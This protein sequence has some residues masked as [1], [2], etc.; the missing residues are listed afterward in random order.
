MGRCVLL[1]ERAVGLAKARSIDSIYSTAI[2]AVESLVDFGWCGVGIVE[3]GSLRYRYYRGLTLPEGWSMP[4]DGRGVTVRAV[5]TAEAQYVPDVRRD[6]DYVS[7]SPEDENLAELVVPVVAG[8][9]VRAVINVEGR[10]VDSITVED[11]ELVAAL[12]LHVGAALER[13]SEIEALEKSVAEKTQELLEAS[14]MVAAGRVAA[15]VAHDIKG[16]LQLIKNMV[17][18]SKRRPERIEEFLGKIVGAVDYANDMIEDVRQA[19]KEAPMF[20]APTDLSKVIREGAAVAE[21]V[22]D[23]VVEAEVEALGTQLVDGVK[24]RRVVENLVRNAMDAMPRGGT[25]RVT[26]RLQ[27]EHIVVTVGDTGTG[28][29]PEFL[30]RLFRAFESTKTQGM[31]LGL[32]FCK[33]TV[34][35]HGGTIEVSSEAGVG[36]T[37]TI[38]LPSRPAAG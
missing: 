21:G 9:E 24:M 19:T 4:L 2:E 30:P 10:R 29:P 37:F 6:P 12:A 7:P 16:P 3:G 20:L 5:R 35:A 13:L 36:T 34:E 28:I 38:R 15:T 17:Y 18:L 33:Q 14:K 31:G 26:A 32:N 25:V 8:G 22:A 11:R 1:N 23:I 27:G